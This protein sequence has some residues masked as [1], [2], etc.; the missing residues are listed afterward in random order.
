MATMNYDDIKK[1]IIDLA[2][3]LI[4]P[5]FYSVSFK[6]SPDSDAFVLALYE[7]E[8]NIFVETL[9]PTIEILY[10]QHTTNLLKFI[11]Q[12]LLQMKLELLKHRGF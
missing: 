8:H 10:I 6:L 7:K 2:N 3:D 5:E 1:D 11:E 9:I 4:N 12:K